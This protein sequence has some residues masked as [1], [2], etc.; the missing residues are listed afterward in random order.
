MMRTNFQT[1]IEYAD[2]P[3]FETI[4]CKQIPVVETKLAKHP[5]RAQFLRKLGHI[6]TKA[7]QIQ[8]KSLRVADTHWRAN[9]YPIAL[10]VSIDDKARTVDVFLLVVADGAKQ[11]PKL[12]HE[13]WIAENSV[14]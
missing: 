4:D 10:E 12:G 3:S 8:L 2:L 11:M 9:I 7:R 14:K 6:K 13:L 1:A 5:H